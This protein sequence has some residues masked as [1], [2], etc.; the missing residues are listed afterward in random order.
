VKLPEYGYKRVAEAGW[1]AFVAIAVVI[2]EALI[3]FNPDAIQDWKA[4]GIA[5]GAGAV[6]AAAGA[7]LAV[8]TKPV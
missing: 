2:L 5:I 8:F 1:F 3:K 6:R 4:W 7:L